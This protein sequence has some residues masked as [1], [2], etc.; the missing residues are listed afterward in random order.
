MFTANGT[1][2]KPATV[3]KWDANTFLKRTPGKRDT[4]DK[5][6]KDLG[7]QQNGTHNGTRRDRDRTTTKWDT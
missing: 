5:Y 6:R 1:E 4:T 2:N 3:P 7:L